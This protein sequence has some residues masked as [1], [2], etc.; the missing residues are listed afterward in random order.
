MLARMPNGGQPAFSPTDK[1]SEPA[2]ES[3]DRR[4]AGRSGSVRRTLEILEL[5]AAQGGASAREISEAT[6][7]PLPTV[8]RLARELLDADY[9]VH[10]REE[11]RFELGYKL[12]RLGVSLHQ[13]IGVPRAVRA[14]ISALHERLQ[15]AAYFAIHRGM[16]IVVVAIADSPACPRLQP[17]G[18]GYHEATHATALGKIL[19][20]GMTDDERALHLDPEPMPRFAAATITTHDELARQLDAVARRGIAWEQGEFQDGATCAA[21]AVRAGSGALIGSVAV[22]APDAH[23]ADDRPGIERALRETASTVSRYYRSGMTT[24]P[25][26]PG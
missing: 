21:A 18:F 19:L 26:R 16:Q 9:L 2:P 12:H 8:Y 17:L 10:I 25:G 15:S 24:A 5:V 6:G 4:D 22:S 7:L 1:D 3:D 23:F 13:Q 20:A 11:K 14:E